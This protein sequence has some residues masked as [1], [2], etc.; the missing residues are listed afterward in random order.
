MTNNL[1]QWKNQRVFLEWA[2]ERAIWE[3]VLGI[4]T[5]RQLMVKDPKYGSY[6]VF[7]GGKASR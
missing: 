7:I 2:W 1:L 6:K 3:S 5:T 4:C